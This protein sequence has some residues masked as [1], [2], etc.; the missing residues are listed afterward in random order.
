MRKTLASFKFFFFQPLTSFLNQKSLSLYMKKYAW[1]NV[2]TEDLWSVLSEESG[3]N[4][5]SLMECWTKQK[6]HPVVYVN[7]KDNLLEFKQ[8][9]TLLDKLKLHL[10][11]SFCL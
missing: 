10:Q 2:E 3:I 1:K 7:C 5:T 8:V 11:I 6:G 9:L 4:I